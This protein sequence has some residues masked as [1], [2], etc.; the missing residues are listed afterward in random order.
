MPHTLNATATS[1][2]LVAILE[3]YQREDG[4]VV[5]PNAL[6]LYMDG[7]D[8]I[9]TSGRPCLRPSAHSTMLRRTSAK[10]LDLLRGEP[11]PSQNQPT[12][13]GP[14]HRTPHKIQI[15]NVTFT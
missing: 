8:A 15:R 4:A 3:N 10:D 14:F 7:K 2:G 11:R 6:R 5:V 13:R 9:G 12:A 1:R